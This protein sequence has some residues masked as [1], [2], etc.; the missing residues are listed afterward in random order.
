MPVRDGVPPRAHGALTQHANAH[1]TRAE[2]AQGDRSLHD[3]GSATANSVLWDVQSQDEACQ[4]FSS[5]VV[6]EL[7]RHA[8]E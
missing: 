6:T 8:A 5:R 7:C 4:L 3:S 2:A 1:P